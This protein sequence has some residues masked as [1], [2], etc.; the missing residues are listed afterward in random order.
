[1]IAQSSGS[2]MTRVGI[3]VIAIFFDL[4][5][6]I[7]VAVGT[8]LVWPGTAFDIV[9]MLK[10]DREAMLMPHRM[11]F[12]PMFLLFAV[13]AAMASYGFFL[14]RSWA[15]Q[16]AI[17]IFAANGIGDAVQLALG[18]VLEGGIGLVAVAALLLFLFSPAVEREFAA[19]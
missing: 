6:C 19:A 14:R 16:L 2:I 5:T 4:A 8:A 15:R 9:W 1:M 12:G 18:R 13:P 11:L 17:A 10:S 7:L 3:V